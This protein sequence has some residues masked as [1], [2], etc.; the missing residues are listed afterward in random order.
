[1]TIQQHLDRNKYNQKSFIEYLDQKNIVDYDVL[2]Q[3][4]NEIR[5]KGTR[6]ELGI[7]LELIS[8]V[9][10]N[11]HRNPNFFTK[12][13]TV[14]LQFKDVIKEK[15]TNY[16]IFQKFRNNKRVLLILFKHEILTADEYI[17]EKLLNDKGQKSDC[18]LYFYPELQDF[19]STKEKTYIEYHYQKLTENGTNLFELERRVGENDDPICQFIQSDEVNQFISHVKNHKISLNTTIPHS[20][21]ETNPFLIGKTPTLIEYSAFYGSIQIINYMLLNKVKLTPSV[22]MYAIHSNNLQ[23]IQLL[24]QRRIKP[25][26]E[27]YIS[28]LKESIKCHHLELT[29][30]ILTKLMKTQSIEDYKVRAKA[31]KYVNYEY[32]PNDLTNPFYFY[33]LCQ[34]NYI[35]LVD[36]LLRYKDIDT[37][38]HVILNKLF[39]N[40]ISNENFFFIKF[41]FNLF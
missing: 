29:N 5:F 7:I 11:H 21:F 16:E 36:F 28:C 10:D 6:F 30:Y 31:I 8:V 3:Y 23:L 15:F 27:T 26:D 41:Q 4:F 19:I 20:I 35:T 24:E 38:Y 9:A 18:Q 13:E 32:F 39:I 37:S 34:N 2:Y 12:I 14:L 33:K 17:A 1:M 40:K 22:W 25:E